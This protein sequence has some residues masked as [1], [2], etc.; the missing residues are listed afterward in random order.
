LVDRFGYGK[1]MTPQSQLAFSPPLSIDL[2]AQ[3]IAEFCQR[4]QIAELALFGSV[5][6]SDFRPDSDVDVLITFDPTAKRSLLTLVQ[7]KDELETLWGR[8]VDVVSKGAVLASANWIRRQ[9]ILTTA[10]VIYVA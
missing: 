1:A 6:R 4:W 2:P 9:E 3:T 8:A 5:L 10:R 7:I